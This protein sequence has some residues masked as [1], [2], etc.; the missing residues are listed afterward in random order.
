VAEL[1]ERFEAEH[2]PRKR[3]GTAADYRR[4]INNHIAPHFGKSLKVADVTH[5]HVQQLHDR[6]SKRGHLH[7]A[8]RA[9]AVLS[10]M[11][12][13]AIRWDM[14]ADN[15]C[16]GLERHYEA[17]RKRYVN[18]EELHR[19]IE[20]LNA[21]PEQSTANVFRLLL[22]TGARRGEVL[23]MRWADIDLTAAKWVKPG[24]TTKQK[25]DHEVPLSA[26]VRLLLSGIRE[27]QASK[28][29]PLGE[30][31]FPGNGDSGHVVAVKKAW[32]SICRSAGISGLRIHDLRHSFASALVSSG[33]SLPLI[34]ALLGH[35]S[36]ST[37]S[38]YSH[39][40][41]D[42]LKA[43]VEQVGEVITAA[44]KPPEPAKEPV[45]FPPRGR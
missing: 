24:S 34:G 38:R 19:L 7:R 5:D 4:M 3:E 14:R 18:G 23:S 36:P 8:N 37:T 31:V 1:I 15:P 9:I 43:A 13:L 25:T 12:S 27:K 44:G 16:K 41:D 11:F 17:K 10:K 6:I 20:A 45:K 32:A 21:Y 22:L 2:L 26:P 42:P 39:L 40:H 29:K 35:S 28:S 33:H 30:F